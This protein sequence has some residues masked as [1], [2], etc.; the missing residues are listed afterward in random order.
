MPILNTTLS[1]NISYLPL[2]SNSKFSADQVEN[3]LNPPQNPIIKNGCKSICSI[4]NLLKTSK[5][6][7]VHAIRFAVSVD[8]ITF[9]LKETKH[10]EIKN[11][12]TLPKPPPKKTSRYAIYL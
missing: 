1:I 2:C 4:K 6:T 8:Q 9:N 11:R 12:K 5:A 3:V 10:P 7:I